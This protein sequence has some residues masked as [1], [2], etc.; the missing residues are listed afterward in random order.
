MTAKTLTIILGDQRILIDKKDLRGVDLSK[1]IISSEGYAKIGKKLLSRIIMNPPVDMEVDHRNL[2]KLDNRRQNLRIC[3]HSE[4]MM[5]RGKL[6]NNT[7]GFKGVSVDRR[8]K[9]KIFRVRIATNGKPFF[10]GCFESPADGAKAYKKA[11]KKLH[12]EFARIE[13]G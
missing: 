7:C 8:C 13:E 4:N 11:A 10:L 2:D 3:T 6:K 5:N 1:L 9:K 12:G